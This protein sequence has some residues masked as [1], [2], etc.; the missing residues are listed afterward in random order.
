M[1]LLKCISEKAA[2][3]KSKGHMGRSSWVDAWRSHR[4]GVILGH[5]GDPCQSADNLKGLQPGVTHARAGAALRDCG[6][7]WPSLEQGERSKE[8]QNETLSQDLPVGS[9]N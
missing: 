3:A 5:R 8:Q 4:E 6:H 2:A 7:G 1:P 9:Q